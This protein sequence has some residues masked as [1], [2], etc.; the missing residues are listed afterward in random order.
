MLLPMFDILISRSFDT[1]HHVLKLVSLP[2]QYNYSRLERAHQNAIKRGECTNLAAPTS[3]N[4]D[5]AA[6]NSNADEPSAPRSK[7]PCRSISN[8]GS[9]SSSSSSRSRSARPTV[10]ETEQGLPA[11]SIFVQTR[12]RSRLLAAAAAADGTSGRASG[13]SATPS[14][15]SRTTR[16]SSSLGRRRRGS[17]AGGGSAAARISSSSSSPRPRAGQRDSH[18]KLSREAV[19]V[20]PSTKGAAGGSSCSSRSTSTSCDDAGNGGVGA[21]V[22][23]VG[24]RGGDD[25]R[26]VVGSSDVFAEGVASKADEESDLRGGAAGGEGATSKRKQ[27][28][29]GSGSG[30]CS[31]SS[32][33]GNS[34][35]KGKVKEAEKGEK[36]K[37]RVSDDGGATARGEQGVSSGDVG[38]KGLDK[39]VE[40]GED[41]GHGGRVNELDPIML[42][43]IGKDCHRFVRPN[44]RV[45]LYN[46][47]SL[48]DYFISTG[49]FLEPETRL[50][51]SDEEL[52]AIDIKVVRS[53]MCM[54]VCVFRESCRNRSRHQSAIGV[55]VL[56]NCQQDGAL[57][58][59]IQNLARERGLMRSAT[60]FFVS[61][62]L[63][64]LLGLE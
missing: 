17:A 1:Q 41:D 2:H 35:G 3:N 43:K 44:G 4:T 58:N 59:L 15:A 6:T 61:S 5:N 62:G 30:P 10:H 16:A 50:P 23:A 42:M 7:R 57:D 55:L 45:V 46:L 64:H 31:S 8:G 34:K 38:C 56:R 28:G 47:D 26:G 21:P 51:F 9:G 54:Y 11:A 18:L 63:E 52:R 37:G 53:V 40:E 60:I 12:S 32:G 19:A 25:S 39:K 13:A 49:D 36:G 22:P 48:V 14:P 29:S 20:D 33:H 24:N 27:P